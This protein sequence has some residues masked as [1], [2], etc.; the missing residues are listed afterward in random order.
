[1]SV[2]ELGLA[3]HGVTTY[4]AAAGACLGATMVSEA[5]QPVG[6]PDSTA[7]AGPEASLSQSTS[8][9]ERGQM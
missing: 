6:S 3:M 2:H 8:L 7:T 5:K 1:M 9:P 4:I